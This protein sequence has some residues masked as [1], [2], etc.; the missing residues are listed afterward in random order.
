RHPLTHKPL[1]NACGLYLHQRH[2]LR[3]QS[4]IM[5]DNETPDGGGSGSEYDGPKCSNCGTH[6]TSTWRRNKAGNQVCNACGVYE[7]MNGKPRPLAL[8]NDKIRPGT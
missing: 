8:R 2:E 4:L 1:C 7:R 3:P 5:V 6:K